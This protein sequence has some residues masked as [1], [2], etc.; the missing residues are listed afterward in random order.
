MELKNYEIQVKGVDNGYVI[1]S[2]HP[3]VQGTKKQL[4]ATDNDDLK[5]KM[6]DLV[7]HMFDEPV[8]PER[9]P[10]TLPTAK[11]TGASGGGN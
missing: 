5:T 8:K 9:L 7:D 3:N 1:Q 6:K 4:I 10:Q 2:Q 11:A